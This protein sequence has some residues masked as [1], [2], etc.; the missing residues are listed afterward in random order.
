MDNCNLKTIIIIIGYNNKQISYH[1]NNKKTN[2]HKNKHKTSKKII[3]Y[4]TY[5]T[6]ND[7][8]PPQA[9]EINKTPEHNPIKL[10]LDINNP[11]IIQLELNIMQQPH[12]LLETSLLICVIY[13]A[14]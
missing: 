12:K 10:L 13:Q 2:K 4:Y 1:N 6:Q 5:N 3:N 14:H 11:T 8:T 9:H 7:V